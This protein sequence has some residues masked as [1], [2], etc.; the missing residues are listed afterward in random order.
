VTILD[1]SKG[2]HWPTF[3]FLQ[4][5]APP[6]LFF[7]QTLAPPNSSSWELWEEQVCGNLHTPGLQSFIQIFRFNK[8][9]AVPG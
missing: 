7:L 9:V 2:R 8:T 6:D 4:T 3:S 5:L 1:N